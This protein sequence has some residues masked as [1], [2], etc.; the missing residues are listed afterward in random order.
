MADF[1]FG[2]ATSAHQVEGNN[3]NSD[4]WEFEDRVLSKNGIHSGK[5]CNH[6]ELYEEDIQL[7]KQLGHN[8]HRLSIEWAKVEPQ[9]GK[10]DFEVIEH[11]KKVLEKLKENGITPVVTL[12]HFSLP[13]WLAKKGG[14][15]NKRTIKVFSDYAKFITGELK[16]YLTYII[17]INEPVVY[18]YQGYMTGNWPPQKNKYRLY[19]KMK[20]NLAKAHKKVYHVLKS[21]NPDLQIS[22]AKNNQVFEAARKGN[23]FDNMLV[24]YFE[25]DWNHKYLDMTK[26]CLDFIG[27]NYYFY[28]A[29]KFKSS[30]AKRFYQ[31]PYPTCRKTDMNWEVYPKGMYLS[32]TDLWKKYKLPII[33][34]EN[35]VADSKDKLRASM[36]K[37]TLEWLF[38]AKEEGVD[39]RGY[40]HWSLLDNFEWD[41]GFEP[42]FGL[43]KVDYKNFARSIRPSALLYKKLIEEYS[44]K[45]KGKNLHS[46][47]KN[48]RISQQIP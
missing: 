23:P 32:L 36:I 5:A 11:Y 15:A 2:A 13:L 7:A 45:K 27:L 12:F 30:L 8:A 9:E 3:I 20:K 44:S 38:K 10:I 6:W 31:F 34:T 41:S 43:I 48:S 22:V 28:R 47:V 1:L 40:L 14:F 25:H 35:G 21:R 4:W 33:V 26:G 37:E 24:K 18:S 46:E 29:V 17:T 16:E 39:V 42:E 19:R